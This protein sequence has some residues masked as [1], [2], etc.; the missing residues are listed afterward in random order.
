MDC[1]M[2]GFPV[3]YQLLE[4]TK[5]HVHWVRDAIQQSHSAIPFFLH[6]QSFTASGSFQMT[7]F[8]ASVGQSIGVSASASFLP[9]NIQGF[10]SFRIYWF[11]LCSPRDSQESS[12]VP[13]FESIHSLALSLLYGPPLTSIRDYWK[14][15]SFHCTDLSKM[16]HS[17][18]NRQVDGICL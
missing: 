18:D 11:D 10:F 6:L 17:Y 2:P 7:Q 8:L 16:A 14:H 5:T 12:P 15:H 4:F 13:Q 1:S 3:H 9:M